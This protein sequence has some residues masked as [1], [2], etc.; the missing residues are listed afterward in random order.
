VLAVGVAVE[1]TGWSQEFMCSS[2]EW[3]QNGKE[4]DG[5]CFSADIAPL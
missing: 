5:I 1:H 3:F 4:Q 2:A